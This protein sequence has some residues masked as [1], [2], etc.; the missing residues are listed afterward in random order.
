MSGCPAP[1]LPRLSLATPPTLATLQVQ[2]STVLYSTVLTL[3]TVQDWACTKCGAEVSHR[4]AV[5]SLNCG[6]QLV[7]TRSVGAVCSI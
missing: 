1:V 6:S 3:A 4:R 5:T 7:H 2:Y